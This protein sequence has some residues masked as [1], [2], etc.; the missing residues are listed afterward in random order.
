VVDF[1][2]EPGAV[3][4]AAGGTVTWRN[5]G[6]AAHSVS[7]VDSSFDSG[8]LQP[9]G[10]FSHTFDLAG[11]YRYV[12]AFHPQMTATIEIVDAPPAPAADGGAGD[13]E[14]AAAPA[15]SSSGEGSSPSGTAV[16]A[17]LLGGAA[18]LAGAGALLYGG[19]RMVA[20]GDGY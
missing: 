12:C 9:A 14:Q 16:L 8:L 5:N 7:A 10:T 19:S 11:T 15:G 20:A 6:V 13:G 3:R 4:L 17:A 18:L 2:F 1:A